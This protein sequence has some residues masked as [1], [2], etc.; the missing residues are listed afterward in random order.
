[1]SW[2]E[3]PLWDWEDFQKIFPKD[4]GFA[5]WNGVQDTN[6]A[7][8]QIRKEVSSQLANGGNPWGS[9]TSLQDPY[10][11]IETH[12]KMIV[13][14]PLPKGINTR[15]L[16]AYLVGGFIKI[17]GIGSKERMIPLPAMGQKRGVSAAIKDHLLEIYI[18]KSNNTALIPIDIRNLDS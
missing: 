10:N 12:D 11:V 4:A 7:I 15:R 9:L 1:M 16:S 6:D 8:H 5:G 3:K 13:K 18:P 2:K 17:K 14:V